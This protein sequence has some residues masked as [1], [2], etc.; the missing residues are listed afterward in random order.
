MHQE[1]PFVR[2]LTRLADL[3]VVGLLWTV[4]ALPLVTLPAA[5]TGLCAVA[6]GWAVGGS[7]PVWRTFVEGFRRRFARGLAVG[8]VL[9][10]G[11]V[12]VATD[13]AFGLRA[14]GAPLRGAVL[15]CG[16]ALAAAVALAGAFAFPLLAL[17]TDAALPLLRNATLLACANPLGALGVWAT[18]AAGAGASL[19]VPP[20][21]PLAAAAG[22]VAAARLTRLALARLPAGATAPAGARA[23]AAG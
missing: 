13:V 23:P 1:N 5:T 2:G 3:V 6:D 17:T 4:A 14:E 16:V 7:P 9:G 12:L 22:A 19:A 10:L 11:A 20:L 15:T 18:V 21:L 8:G